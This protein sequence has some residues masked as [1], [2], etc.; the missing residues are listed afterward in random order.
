MIFLHFFEGGP[1]IDKTQAAPVAF[2]NAKQLV[3]EA[4]AV[5]DFIDRRLA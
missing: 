5:G 4:S 1:G 3:G 2:D